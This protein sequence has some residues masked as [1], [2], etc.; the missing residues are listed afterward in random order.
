M[1]KL[2][3]DLPPEERVGMDG[4]RHY[5][6]SNALGS[7]IPMTDVAEWM[8]HKPIE[9]TYSTY[10]HLMPRSITKAARILPGRRVRVRP[11][12]TSGTRPG[13]PDRAAHHAPPVPP[14]L[15]G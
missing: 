14:G 8:G 10:R 15:P 2:F 12:A 9:E 13:A 1:R 3:A 11:S 5:F 6:A 7:G 4:F